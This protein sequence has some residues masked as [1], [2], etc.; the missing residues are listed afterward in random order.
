MGKTGAEL[1]ADERARQVSKEGWDATHDAESHGTADTEGDLAMAAAAY[2]VLCKVEDGHLSPFGDPG[3]R[4]E[5]M[6]LGMKL[7]PWSSKEIKPRG[8][9]RN[10]IRA[11]ALIAAEIDRRL[12]AGESHA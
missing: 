8:H 7:W 1:I 6:T 5:Y 10:L 2:C 12:A 11:G 9:M 3:D 4:T